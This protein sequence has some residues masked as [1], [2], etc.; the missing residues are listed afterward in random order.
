YN[1]L[2]NLF[3]NLEIKN[4]EIFKTD[5]GNSLKISYK[6]FTFLLFPFIN[7]MAI[8]KPKKEGE[9]VR[10]LEPNFS[11]LKITELIENLRNL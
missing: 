6:E 11:L 4:L 1:F 9:V 5:K 7:E 8:L 10:T 2:E 3:Q